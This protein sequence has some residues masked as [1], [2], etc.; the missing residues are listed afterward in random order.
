[1]PIKGRSTQSLA[2]IYPPWAA[3]R[4][5]E[6]SQGFQFLNTLG[7]TFDDLRKQGQLAVANLTIPTANVADIDVFRAISLPSTY[8]FTKQTDDTTTLEYTPPVVSG[9][10]GSQA[11]TLQLAEDNDIK[12]FWYTATPTRLSLLQTADAS[13]YLLASGQVSQ[14]PLPILKADLFAPNRI[15]VEL[16]GATRCVGLTDTN[17][18]QRGLIQ[19][20]GTT[21]DGVP[22]TEEMAFI[23]D[24]SRKTYHE[25]ASL[26]G[27]QAFGIQEAATAHLRIQAADFNAPDRLITYELDNTVGG[28]EVPFFWAVGSGLTGIKTLDLKKHDVDD[29]LLRL[30]GF[31]T[32]Q[33]ILQQELLTTAGDANVVALDVVPEPFTDNLWVVSSGSLHLYSAQL[34]YPNCAQMTQ[35][36]YDAPV[37]IEPSSYHALRGEA[38]SL[39]YVWLRPTTGLVAHRVW[40][41]YPDGT[42]YSLENGIATAYHSDGDSWILGEP[43]DR[44][45]RAAEIYTLSQLGD[46]IFSIEAKYTD[47]TTTIDQRIVTVE[48]QRAVAEYG[49]A[50]AGIPITVRAVGLDIDSDGKLWILGDNGY[51][52]RLERHYDN[53]LIDFTQKVIYV[54][55]PYDLM[56]VY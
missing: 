33:V 42:K 8:T 46:Y 26:S 55:E 5:D 4:A 48:A 44:R 12:S 9:Y 53:M 49:L 37:V 54:R 24:E 1:M 36:Q 15:T 25:F 14:S 27:V 39:D 35:K 47:S 45:V 50:A 52:Y 2:N 19:V 32:K 43:R 30:D 38:I 28:E 34:P 40:V 20:T 3:I 16:T 41:Q 23:F 17:E 6:Q 21:R 11:Y 7:K 31:S 13:N 51:G 22:L 10:I 29:L 56:R 18:F